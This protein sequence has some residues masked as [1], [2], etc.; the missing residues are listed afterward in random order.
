[1][2][3]SILNLLGLLVL[4]TTVLGLSAASAWA[5]P[6][7]GVT[8]ER[9]EA[10]FPTVRH[11][12]ER[13]DFTVKVKN[14][15]AVLGAPSEGESLSCATTNS[16][17]DWNFDSFIN[18]SF[19]FE[20]VRDGTVVAPWAPAARVLNANADPEKSEFTTYISTYTVQAADAEHAIQCLVKGTNGAGTGSFVTASQPVIVVN[21]QPAVPPPTPNSIGS[22][23]IASISGSAA[24]AGE[25]LTCTAP[26]AGWS[27]S[28][29]ASPISWSFEWLR[30]GELAP[31][32]VTPVSA[33]ESEYELTAADVSAPA[34]PAV[35]QCVAK[36][37]NAAGAALDES[38]VVPTAF[39]APEFVGGTEGG[40]PQVGGGGIPRVERDTNTIAGPLTVELELPGGEETFAL[41]IE[42]EG[43]SCD[44]LS[45]SGLQPARVVCTLE[46]LISPQEEFPPLEVITALGADAPDIATAKATA[47]GGG[48]G[49]ASDALSF[50]IEPALPFGIS[51]FSANLF[52]EDEATDY[53]QAGGHPFEGFSH[54]VFNRKRGLK[55]EHPIDRGPVAKIRQAI[56][57]IPPGVVGNPLAIPALCPTIEDVKHGT[58]PPA[59]AVGKIRIEEAS[60]NT[61]EY[62]MLAIEPE[63]GTPAQFAFADVIQN[64]YVFS[65][66]LRPEDG[67][68]VSLELGPAP[69]AVF[70]IDSKVTLCDF[71]AKYAG[72]AVS[73]C[74]KAGE[75]GANPKPFL[76]N[77]TRCGVPLTTRIQVN[78]WV[79]PTFVE[80]SPFAN[81]EVEG[82]DKVPFE[83]TMKVTPTTSVADSPTGL[84]AELNVPTEGLE[85]AE[86]CHEIQDD[87]GS[88]LAPECL[89]E[90]NLRDVKVTLP[91]GLAVNPAGAN[92]LEACSEA[93]VGIS[94]AGVPNNN[95]VTCPD[96][97]KI[98]SA[99]VIT[100]L[101][102]KPLDGAVYQAEQDRNPF[103]STL[104]VYLVA[105]QPESGIL[106][107]LVGKVELDP[108]TG[109]ITSTFA[110]NPQ[111]PFKTF[112]LHF[113]GGASAPL[114]TPAACGTYSTTSVLTPWS[115]PE[116]GPPATITNSYAIDQAPGGGEC[117]T[118]EG[119]LPSAPEF[120]AGTIRP[121]AGAYSPFVVRL[122]RQDGSQRFGAVKLTPPPGLTAKLA[123]T[124][125]CSEAALA[126]AA[127][128]SGREEQAS[129]SCPA[130]SHVGTAHVATG[131]GPAPF[132]AKGE[133]YL[134]GPYKGAPLSLA[135]ITP[136]V[137]GPFDLGTVVVRTALRVD[138]ASAQITAESDPIPQM[139]EGIPLD[140]RTVA[141]ALDKPD[142]T[143]NGT[144][145]AEM[146]FTGQLL[147]PLGQATPLAER[148]QLGECAR[149]RFK[150]AISLNLTGGTHRGDYEGVRATVTYP[151]GTGYA[152]IARTAV[153]LP[154]AAF[155][156]QNHIRTVCTRV[157]F[158]ADQCPK[159]SIYGRAKATTPLL[160][161]P[162]AGPVYLRSSNHTLPDLVVKLRGPDS[163]PIEVDL[164]GRTD[165]VKGALRNTF[166]IVPDAPVK[167]FSLQL[168]GGRRGLIE[169]SSDDYCEQEHRATVDLA[170]Q[171]GLRR[172]LHPVL[173]NPHCG[174]Q[175]KGANAKHRH[176][177][178]RSR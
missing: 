116:S 176:A 27:T 20:W 5:A 15:A 37:T 67:Y 74:Y 19:E 51:E 134:A 59:S 60:D 107:K 41:K 152:N 158:A 39:P 31:G 105:Q 80:G 168:F 124:P 17:S 82:C 177:A 4:A 164:A 65:A 62:A 45:A 172:T 9:D 145:C 69:E 6:Q 151:E 2:K 104:A 129:P 52:E 173:R 54:V 47:F 64:V 33:T 8:L 61:H 98:G 56:A 71:G 114:R 66:H 103:G 95:P 84:D 150:P 57:D 13:V 30:D 157:Q 160:D 3:R 96:A 89:S 87:E 143:R 139:L 21:P 78:S 121:I 97:S 171:N 12:D 22:E 169:L 99:E 86:E 149:L 76:T 58:C 93:Q 70:V 55:A 81:A 170:A 11:S 126:A 1:M 136:A 141:I 156:A 132:W 68:A 40:T 115:A 128:K 125:A 155:L 154:H 142:F 63:A 166:E 50:P 137:A 109:Q 133:A 42:G 85:K 148:F 10:E 144:S 24:N 72:G 102:E 7:L 73:G 167:K 100:P 79:D 101:L 34:A 165:S 53:T 108:D 90:A 123:G 16:F 83:P 138:P 77:P 92:G 175:R 18:Y 106:V 29:E 122:Q 43:W 75:A 135:I 23:R 140:V 35:F 110:D 113:F 127:S 163:Q 119:A 118:S 117:P 48:A 161:Y 38:P 130:A 46:E 25:K 36:A 111:V 14:E 112:K 159:G 91:E 120:D 147:S 32:T 26:T 94:H 49:A 44:K 146:G 153:T 28:N 88:P 178:R 131:A 174:A 162:L